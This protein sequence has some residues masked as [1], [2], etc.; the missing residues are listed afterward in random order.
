VC[1]LL[2]GLLVKRHPALIPLS[3]DHRQG[4]FLAQIL[5]PG[6]PRYQGAP[7]TP[8]AKR[9]YAMALYQ[10]LLQPHMRAEEEQLAPLVAGLD[11]EIARLLDQLQAEHITLHQHFQALPQAAAATLE[12]DLHALGQLLEGHIRTEERQLFQRIQ[13]V[14]DEAL[15]AQIAERTADYRRATCIPLL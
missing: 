6:T 15:L 2:K 5:K 12:A 3:H 8:S 4:L 11:S 10:Q 1:S 9:D 7:A 13:T 14:A